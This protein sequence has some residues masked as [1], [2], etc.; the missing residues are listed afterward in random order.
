MDDAFAKTIREFTICKSWESYTNRALFAASDAACLGER[1]TDLKKK[2]RHA[3]FESLLKR[4]EHDQ[5]HATCALHGT[6]KKKSERLPHDEGPGEKE[7]ADDDTYL[8][9]LLE[10]QEK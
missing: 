3:T 6:L 9:E 8:L 10:F 4:Q 1:C 2:S 5:I 7:I